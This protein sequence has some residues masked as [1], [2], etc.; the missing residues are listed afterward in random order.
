[1]HVNASP[2]VEVTGED[3]C[4]GSEATFTATPGY[5]SYTFTL[6]DEAPVTQTSNIF[7]QVL[8]ADETLTSFYTVSVSAVDEFGCASSADGTATIKVTSAP[9]FTFTTLD[10]TETHE[11][12]ANTGERYQYIWMVG[13]DCNEED[14]LVYVEYDIYYEGELLTL[15]NI[16]S[17]FCIQNSSAN[18]TNRQWNTSNSLLFYDSDNQPVSNT[19]Y[20]LGATPNEFSLYNYYG[21]HFPYS[22]LIHNYTTSNYYDD[23]WMHF[24]RNREVTQTVAP[25]KLSGDYKFVFRL[26]QTNRPNNFQNIH[27]DVDG[28]ISAD[29]YTDNGY[30]ALGG[31][32][33]NTDFADGTHPTLTLLA[34]D[35][36]MIHVDGPEFVCAPVTAPELAPNL[37]VDEANVAPDMEVWPN[38][39]PAITTTLKARVHNMSGEA[40]V[41][42]TSLSGTQIYA[43]KTFIDNDNYYFE[44]G[45]NNLSVGSYIL[46]VRT[47]DAIITKKVVVSSLAQ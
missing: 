17:Y 41:T 15:D 34:L 42:L 11:F 10:G 6:G 9:Q 29:G 36:I 13:G 28:T 37:T 35:S 5:A 26:Y 40:T 30:P 16:S 46:T 12:D 31:A 1:L 32:G 33:F 4:S 38:P 25:F 2:V 24:L 14:L 19:S 27:T 3:I 7:T 39:A 20:Y 45:V 18:G 44:F 23:L 43:G 21:N 22:S 47:G 8:N